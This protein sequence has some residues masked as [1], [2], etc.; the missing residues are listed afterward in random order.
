MSYTTKNLLPCI[1][2]YIKVISII[3]LYRIYFLFINIYVCMYV[4]LGKIAPYIFI[5]PFFHPPIFSF[6]LSFIPLYFHSPFLSSPYIFIL[7]FFHPPIFSPLFMLT[8]SLL[9][10]K[11]ITRKLITQVNSKMLAM[12][13]SVLH[14]ASMFAVIL[15]R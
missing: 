14:Y 4:C 13:F 6:S 15:L 1:L 9:L 2:Q 7:P 12:Y 10:S 8:C 11:L 5:L 3:L